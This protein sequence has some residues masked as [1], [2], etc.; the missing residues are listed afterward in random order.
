MSLR[1]AMLKLLFEINE[2]IETVKKFEVYMR[3]D[4]RTDTMTLTDA[5]HNV[6]AINKS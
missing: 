2:E 1:K 4:G 3:Q 6:K 5:P